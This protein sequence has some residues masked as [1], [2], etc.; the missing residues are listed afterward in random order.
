MTSA[1]STS[2]GESTGEQMQHDFSGTLDST[3]HCDTKASS[4][5][6]KDKNS[7][8]SQ[9]HSWFELFNKATS[10][11]VQIALLCRRALE[12]HKSDCKISTCNVCCS[13]WR[14]DFEIACA[15]SNAKPRSNKP[16]FLSSA[17]SQHKIS[18]STLRWYVLVFLTR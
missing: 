16:G 17:S 3:V 8:I 9:A 15:E 18:S 10:R 6:F 13:F 1:R 7:Q 2:I 12:L 5:V 11:Q 14:L 4:L